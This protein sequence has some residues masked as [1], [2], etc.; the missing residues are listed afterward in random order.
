[1]F[2]GMRAFFSPVARADWLFILSMLRLLVRLG[3]V[4]V[5]TKVIDSSLLL[6]FFLAVRFLVFSLFSVIS[7]SSFSC[8]FSQNLKIL[9]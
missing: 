3:Y 8:N 4:G 9:V 7:A 1:M 2:Q 5:T 6:W